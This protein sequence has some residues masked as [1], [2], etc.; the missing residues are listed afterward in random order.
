MCTARAT[1]TAVMDPTKN[2]K[3]LFIE[4]KC[5]GALTNLPQH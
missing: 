2:K 1:W 5:V 3:K 4:T